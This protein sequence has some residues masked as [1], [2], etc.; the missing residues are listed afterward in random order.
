MSIKALP[1]G[2]IEHPTFER[3]G[4]GL[5]ANRLP[6]D[7]SLRLVAVRG[8]VAQP[9]NLVD[10]LEQLPRYS[11]TADFHCVT[12]WSV[13]NL[14]WSGLRFSD[15]YT[16]IV[17]PIAQPDPSADLV[18]FHGMD[19]Y[20]SSM[21][22]EDLMSED[23]MLADRLND[24]PL[25]LA[26]GAPLRLVAPAHYGYKSVKHLAAIEFWSDRKNY[27]FP[28][29]YP[30]LIDHPRA[31]VDREER[32]R[33]LPPILLRHIYRLLIARVQKRSRQTLEA[34]RASKL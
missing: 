6:T 5:F 24:E 13:R 27:R 1:P 16:A 28:F 9:L 31:R 10:S 8:D 32:V 4:L 18:V 22:L 30:G 17:K 3:F 7:S 26:H 33:Y 14:R 19:G 23:V 34:H 15:V 25:G 29:P 21:I 20:R 11:Q 12:T 2:Q